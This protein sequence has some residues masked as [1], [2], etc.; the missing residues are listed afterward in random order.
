MKLLRNGP[1]RGINKDVSETALRVLHSTATTQRKTADSRQSK[2]TPK[3]ISRRRKR[4][5]K[6]TKGRDHGV[7]LASSP[8]GDLQNPCPHRAAAPK[9]SAAAAVP[10]GKKP[11]S[12]D[13]AHIIVSCMLVYTTRTCS[14]DVH[15]ARRWHSS[16]RAQRRGQCLSGRAATLSPKSSPPRWWRRRRSSPKSPSAAALAQRRRPTSENRAKTAR[17]TY[18][19]TVL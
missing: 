5:K 15:A 16:P 14:T 3:K 9:R 18:K 10:P 7:C 11:S 1:T 17:N 4:E 13:N 6:T 12:A 19:N 8:T 2:R